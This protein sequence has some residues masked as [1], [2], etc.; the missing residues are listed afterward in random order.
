MVRLVYRRLKLKLGKVFRNNT[1]LLPL[2]WRLLSNQTSFGSKSGGLQPKP[3]WKT[4]WKRE[5]S[6]RLSRG[7][8]W[9]ISKKFR[10]FQRLPEAEKAKDFN[11]LQVPI[12]L[13]YSKEPRY[14]LESI[15]S[16]CTRVL[17]ALYPSDP[18]IH[19]NKVAFSIPL[20]L[21]LHPCKFRTKKHMTP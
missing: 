11:H 20:H 16:R 17:V 8:T 13:K 18:W 1:C 7:A 3:W 4:N 5:P 21:L 12:S 15:G 2:P 10:S 14:Q 19:T 6:N 9:K